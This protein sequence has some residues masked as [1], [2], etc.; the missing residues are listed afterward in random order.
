MPEGM[1]FCMKFNI[2]LGS[3]RV[4]VGDYAIHRVECRGTFMH[5]LRG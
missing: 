3:Y 2:N 5:V 4:I 1:H